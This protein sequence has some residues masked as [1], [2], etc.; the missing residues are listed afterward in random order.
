MN[1]AEEDQHPLDSAS[2][3]NAKKTLL[4]LLGRAGVFHAE[5]E[6]LIALVEAGAV[7]DAHHEVRKVEAGAPRGKGELYGAGWEDG[8]QAVV[9]E[10]GAVADRALHRALGPAVPAPS[11]RAGR[12]D[13]PR[14]RPP[15]GRVDVERAKVAVTPLYLAFTHVSDLDPE[16]SDEVLRAVLGTMSAVERAGYAGRLSEFAE[17]RQE[18]LSRLY[19]EYGPGSDI[20]I[21]GRYSLTHSPTSVAVLERLSAAPSLLREEW[22]RAELPPVWLEGLANAWD[23]LPS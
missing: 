23:A 3:V 10:L 9:E 6:E 7:V 4:E 8:A 13:V 20:A 11:P 2:V 18:Q 16:V 15:V 12:M 22:E 5:A 19:A 1:A 17:T 14:G 21:H